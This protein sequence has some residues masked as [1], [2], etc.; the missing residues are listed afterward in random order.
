MD[1]YYNLL[2]SFRKNIEEL[3]KLKGNED[4]VNDFLARL[5]GVVHDQKQ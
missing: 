3:V 4:K 2:K 1:G 5:T